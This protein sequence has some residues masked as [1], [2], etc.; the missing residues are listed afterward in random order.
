[1]LSAFSNTK[2]HMG[3]ATFT[4]NG[5]IFTKYKTPFLMPRMTHILNY[6]YPRN[7]STQS[8]GRLVQL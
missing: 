8:H 2:V 3:Y 7:S 6:G 5:N 4:D 1:M